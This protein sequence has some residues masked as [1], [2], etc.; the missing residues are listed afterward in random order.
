[1]KVV[2]SGDFP[3]EG[4]RHL[5]TEL[6]KILPILEVETSFRGLSS[7]ASAFH[8]LGNV[9]EWKSSLGIAASEF[10]A[11]H[12]QMTQRRI[13]LETVPRT[14]P[15]SSDR[16]S[17]LQQFARSL[18]ELFRTTSSDELKVRLGIPMPD[19]RFG[20]TLNL[21]DADEESI[22][23]SIAAFVDQITDLEEFIRRELSGERKSAGPVDVTPHPDGTLVIRWLDAAAMNYHE[24]TLGRQ[25]TG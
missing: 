1:M 15:L 13:G 5:L 23:L 25:I 22:A 8:M 14:L 6:R 17:S 24:T 4:V 18:R 11:E 10:I 9:S 21:H 19:H 12:R 16:D 20:A 2:L 7:P 3:E